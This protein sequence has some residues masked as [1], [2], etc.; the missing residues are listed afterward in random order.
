[1]QIPD[2]HTLNSNKDPEVLEQ[3]R[4]IPKAPPANES[5]SS[6]SSK[7]VKA[8]VPP[9]QSGAPVKP[10]SQSSLPV[11]RS[12]NSSHDLSMHEELK[13]HD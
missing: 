8:N 9:P 6:N 7:S 1:M 12:R 5:A 4:L 13:K 11:P 10:Q 2:V 3:L